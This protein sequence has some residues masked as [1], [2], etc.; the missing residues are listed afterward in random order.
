MF[1]CIDE[2][3][4]RKLIFV[5]LK[6][7]LSIFVN[8][9]NEKFLINIVLKEKIYS[10]QNFCLFLAILPDK[11]K[12]K[13]MK[14]VFQTANRYH[15]F[16][17]LALLGVPLCRYPAIVSKVYVFSNLFKIMYECKTRLSLR[18]RHQFDSYLGDSIILSCSYEINYRILLLCN[19]ETQVIS[20]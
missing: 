18:H 1:L 16:H 7:S 17:S 3:Q 6:K 8:F 10:F 12:D 4:P 13:N 9:E 5:T 15:F 2:Q 20:R 14:M 11:E 19:C